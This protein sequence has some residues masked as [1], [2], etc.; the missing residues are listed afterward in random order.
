MLGISNNESWESQTMRADNKS[1]IKKPRKGKNNILQVPIM[2]GESDTDIEID[3]Q[4][5]QSLTEHYHNN[6]VDCD[7]AKQCID[8][9]ICFLKMKGAVGHD[10]LICQIER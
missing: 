10:L 9:G 1:H 2:H 4:K 8:R 6:D 5:S 3:V 7:R